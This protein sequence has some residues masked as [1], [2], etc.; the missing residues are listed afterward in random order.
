[1]RVRHKPWARDR[2]AEHP[3]W[4][5]P[6]P[7]THAGHWNEVFAEDQPL[8]VEVGTGKGQFIINMARKHPEYNFIGIE[9][10]SDV[11]VMALEQAL[12]TELDNLRFINGNGEATATYFAP[13]E[14]S[15]LYLNFSDPWPKRRH[16]K[17]RLTHERFLTEY[18][19]ILAKDGTIQ[20]KTDNQSLFE[21]S[22]TS[23]SSFGMAFT[24]VS[25]D[26]H[27]SELAV[28]N[29]TTEYEDKFSAKGQP[30]YYLQARF[31]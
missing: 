26:L 24:E 25:L 17:R 31:R 18:Q 6:S 10:Q 5:I 19:K 8:H 14:V 9:L 4:V 3:E 11:L 23:M 21:Y 20:F 22:L 27:D 30:I 7:E 2:I 13:Q 29:V 1:M 15:Q 28:E 12:E 16:A